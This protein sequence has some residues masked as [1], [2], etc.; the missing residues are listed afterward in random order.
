MPSGALNTHN[1]FPHLEGE[2]APEYRMPSE[3]ARKYREL[4]HYRYLL[5]RHRTDTV[6]SIQYIM[7]QKSVEP[8]GELFSDQWT[9]SV[10]RIDDY[11]I[12]FHLSHIDLLNSEIPNADAMIRSAVTD[13]EDAQLLQTMP[14]VDE[15]L[16][17]AIASR[18]DDIGR[19]SDSS[20]L[21]SYFRMTPR[22]SDG[23][24]R[25]GPP[26]WSRMIRTLLYEAVQR[27]VMDAPETDIS[28][29]HKKLV[30]E[31]GIER[32]DMKAASKMLRVMFWMLKERE[33]FVPRHG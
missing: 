7:W 26:S 8:D 32:A 23:K 31:R 2:E 19:F 21:A 30:E 22:P 3:E 28:I 25:Q 5:E 4:V 18:I 20:N 29:L 15:F 17:L 24:G 16:A 11:R 6:N 9:A 27:H 14:G 10:R 13:Y 33:R 12:S 1:L